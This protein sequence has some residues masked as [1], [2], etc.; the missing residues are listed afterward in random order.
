MQSIYLVIHMFLLWNIHTKGQYWNW[1]VTNALIKSL[2]LSVPRYVDMRDMAN[3]LLPAF[4]QML[5]LCFS[6]L[7][8]ESI[9]TPESFSSCE[10]ST[11]QLPIF[12]PAS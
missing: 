3:S 6:K 4:S 1:L 7:R 9:N 10:L 12:M 2:N 11:V 5:R 8:F